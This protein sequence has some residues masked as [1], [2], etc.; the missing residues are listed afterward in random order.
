MAGCC[1]GKPTDMPW[2]IV[3]TNTFAAT[4]VGTPLDVHLHPTQLYESFA[5]LGILLMLLGMERRSQGFPGRTFWLYVL[6][7]GASRFVTEFYRG[8][9]RGMVFDAISTSQFVSALI[10]PLSIVML[11][12][13]ARFSFT[14]QRKSHA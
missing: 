13:L 1:Y 9:P 6:L 11:V 5:E 14:D 12:Y 3:F 7:Y 4:N 8:D 2:G 10:I